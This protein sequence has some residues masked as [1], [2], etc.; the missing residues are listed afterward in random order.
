[1]VEMETETALSQILPFLF[2]LPTRSAWHQLDARRALG[3]LQFRPRLLGQLL[4][5]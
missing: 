3:A 5:D 4:V 2:L 1:M